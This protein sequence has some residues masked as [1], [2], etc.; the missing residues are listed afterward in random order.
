MGQK[1][2]AKNPNATEVLDKLKQLKADQEQIEDLWKKKNRELSDAKDLQVVL[3]CSVY[4]TKRS[5]VQL[6][7]PR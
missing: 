6:L 7:P 5:W 1:I 3:H 4:V 2:L